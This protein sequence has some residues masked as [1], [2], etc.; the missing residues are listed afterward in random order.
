MSIQEPF[1][2]ME[3]HFFGPLHTFLY[4]G[5]GANHL[6][7]PVNTPHLLVVVIYK[8]EL[9]DDIAMSLSGIDDICLVDCRKE[10]TSFLSLK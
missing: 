7:I 6:I 1:S 5:V 8:L 2:E 3:S 9:S 4:A 10:K